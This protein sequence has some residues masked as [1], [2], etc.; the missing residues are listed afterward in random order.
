MLFFV[1]AGLAR[2][3]AATIAI[4]HMS[5]FGGLGRLYG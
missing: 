4:L 1:G 2:A 5:A 3:G